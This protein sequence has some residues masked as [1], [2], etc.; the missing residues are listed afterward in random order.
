ML[1]IKT[2]SKSTIIRFRY[3]GKHMFRNSAIMYVVVFCSSGL[4]KHIHVFSFSKCKKAY[5]CPLMVI[6]FL[7]SVSVNSDDIDCSLS[8]CLFLFFEHVTR[9]VSSLG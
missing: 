9:A 6:D 5:F 1:F 4:Y 3:L 2:I 8:E 7:S